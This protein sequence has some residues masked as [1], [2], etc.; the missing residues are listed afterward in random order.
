MHY[1]E[2][3]IRSKV[4]CRSLNNAGGRSDDEDRRGAKRK[5]DEDGCEEESVCGPGKMDGDG[6]TNPGGD[7][8]TSGSERTMKEMRGA[9]EEDA[10]ERSEG[11]MWM[12]I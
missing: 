11:R 12:R 5:T 9:S 1:E 6:R 4:G 10:M 7:P 3:R 2:L 8:R